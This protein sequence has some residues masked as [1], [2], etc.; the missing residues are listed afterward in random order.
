MLKK[1]IGWMLLPAAAAVLVACGG[2]GGAG[3]TSGISGV[4][5]TG[6]PIADAPVFIKDSTGAEPT[7][8]N[9]ASGEALATTDENGAYFIPSNLL[10]GLKGPFIVRVV[11]SKVLDNGD[12][13][14]AVL[15]AVVPSGSGTTA[16]LTPLTEAVTILTLGT[17]TA[18]AFQSPQSSVANYTA[19]AAQTANTTLLAKLNLPAGLANIDLVSGSLDA[20]PTT[21]L[22]SPS[23]AKLH[24][25]LLDTFEFSTS[26]GKLV[27]SDRNRAEDEQVSGPQIEISAPTGAAAP[28]VSNRGTMEGVN[29]AGILNSTELQAFIT[30][31]NASLRRGCSVPLLGTYSATCENVVDAS[32]G[33]FSANYR[34][35]G[36]TADKWLSAWVA[37][38][39]D[40]EDL[41]DVTV[42]IRAA[43]RGT[44]MA[45][46]SQRVTR[47][48][49]K[50]ARPNGDYVIRTLLLADEG[51]N[52]TIYGNQKDYF[53]MSRP[54]LTVNTDADD[55][56]PHN[57]KYEV[58]MQFIVKHWYAGRSNMILGAHI[59][60][61]GL[62]AAG[63]R[64]YN[65]KT[66]GIE[67]FR[68]TDVSAGCSNMA[69][70]PKVYEEK[71]LRTWDAAWSA[72][73]LSNY[74]RATLYDGQVRW[75][76]G[77]PTCSSLFD[78]RRYYTPAEL[79]SLALPKR[80]DV[81]TVTL[82]LDATQWGGAGQPAVPAAAGALVS[83]KRNA[84]GDT[85]S[86]YPL[87]V[88][89][90]LRSDAFAVPTGDSTV[91]AALL[92]GV[93][94]ETRAKLVSDAQGKDRSVAWTR[95]LV[96]WPERNAAGNETFTTFGN[97]IVGVFTSSRD[98]LSIADT[99]Y[100]SMFNTPTIPTWSNPTPRGFKD[101]REFF[102]TTATTPGNLTITAQGV[103]S[104]RLDKDCGRVT[105]T[106][107]G[108][109]V[110]VRVRKVTNLGT[111][112]SNDRLYEEVSCD[113]ANAATAGNLTRSS[114]A[115][116]TTTGW[117][118]I[119]TSNN[120]FYRN[121]N[122]GNSETVRYQYDVVRE[123]VSFQSDKST[124]VLGN[125]LS[126]T[127]T[128]AQMMAKEKAGSQ[129]LC[130][131]Y[132]GAWASRKAYVILADMNGRQIQ[133]AREVGA[134]FPGMTA[135]T[136]GDKTLALAS[137]YTA[138]AD[139][140]SAISEAAGVSPPLT[141][142]IDIGRSNYLTD[143]LYLPM[144]MDVSGYD[145]SWTLA[146]G[147]TYPWK[148]TTGSDWHAQP[149]I[150]QPAYEKA[151][152]SATTCTKVNF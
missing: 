58:G 2:G 141:R 75:R 147:S 51:A 32:N 25:M 93:T 84:D 146:A 31:F 113:T 149:G 108:A 28:T 17:N 87:V 8:Q 59:D 38:P 7:G 96:K 72:Y 5:A 129:A 22:S 74:N 126:R 133:E 97:F 48:A 27:L 46:P 70:D 144:M 62:P 67:V 117:Y 54:R 11:G 15:H 122:S 34:H 1:T 69:I 29:T 116:A 45:T 95:N 78:M 107:K 71:N 110:R 130:S 91:S 82:Y 47:V 83:N 56:Y 136:L 123:R 39:L 77:I 73:K 105:D 50:F 109:T 101:Y 43:Y 148:P 3:D 106:Y 35:T 114:D 120:A 55:T 98:Q 13:A 20:V 103:S 121:T 115:A 111:G 14:T 104:G 150:I 94:D 68:R 99:G 80:D 33:V 100:V 90:R 21:N 125:Q 128:W 65:G 86:Y 138:S 30:R 63:T 137:R 131:S 57:P 36:M 79:A 9:L 124:Q 119:G 44:F 6:A 18:S 40:L 132:E 112:D 85:V 26:Q 66:S 152:A 4:A 139:L 64:N 76:N 52:V 10:A 140:A 134:D 60:G 41:G 23:A 145:L 88:T 42:S 143:S 49:L 37:A 102:T 53:L 19:S 135:A 142:S 81:Y 89:E 61:A 92:P 24:D 127:L 151:T 12:D 16:N 118:W